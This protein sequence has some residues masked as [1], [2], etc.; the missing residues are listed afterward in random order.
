MC[1]QGL[2]HVQQVAIGIRALGIDG[3]A[4]EASEPTGR[5]VESERSVDTENEQL[6]RGRSLL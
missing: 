6:R 2:P 1:I 3:R 5:R 4:A